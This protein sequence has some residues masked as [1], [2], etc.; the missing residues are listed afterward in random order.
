MRG[1][2]SFR[3]LCDLNKLP[4]FAIKQG[5]SAHLFSESSLNILAWTRNRLYNFWSNVNKYQGQRI[6]QSSGI[7]ELTSGLGG[8]FNTPPR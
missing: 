1:F 3:I 6:E 5:P 4:T 2:F 7:L 8:R